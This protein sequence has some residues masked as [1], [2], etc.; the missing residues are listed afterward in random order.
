MHADMVTLANRIHAD[1]IPHTK[2]LT[3]QRTCS[4][5]Q[6]VVDIQGRGAEQFD[7]AIF[8]ISAFP[9]NANVGG[10]PFLLSRRRH[11]RCPQLFLHDAQA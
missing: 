3:C 11:F 1:V 2:I 5:N 9:R 8:L 4:N 7:V 6:T 10:S